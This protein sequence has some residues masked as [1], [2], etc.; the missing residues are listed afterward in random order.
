MSA[1][2]KTTKSPKSMAR[3]S[4]RAAPGSET[5]VAKFKLPMPLGHCAAV[6]RLMVRMHGKGLRMKQECQW[7]TMFIPNTEVSQQLGEKT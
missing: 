1:A 3:H 4:L 5:D 6:F 2:N 7:L